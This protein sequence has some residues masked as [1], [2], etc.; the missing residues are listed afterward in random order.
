MHE[1]ANIS[2]LLRKLTCVSEASPLIALRNADGLPDRL[3][4]TDLDV[5]CAP[6]VSLSEAR[7]F[8]RR[9]A[10]STGWRLLGLSNRFHMAAATF[11]HP[12]G[13][14]FLHIDVFRDLSVLGVPLI[15]AE[16]LYRDHLVVNGVR[17]LSPRMETLVTVVHRTLHG[18]TLNKRRYRDQLRFCLESEDG[19]WC[20]E[21]L[22]DILGVRVAQRLEDVAVRDESQ[23]EGWSRG[24]STVSAVISR[25]LVRAPWSTLTRLARYGAGQVTSFLRPPGLVGEPGAA[26]PQMPGLRVDLGFA[27][28]LSIYALSAPTVRAAPTSLATMHPPRYLRML[29][30]RWK[31]WTPLRWILPSIFLWLHAKR[32]GV[33]IVD[34]LPGGLRLLRRA[35]LGRSWIARE[36]GRKAGVFVALLGPDGVG[37]TTIARE[38]IDG[39]EGSTAYVHFR[40]KLLSALPDTPPDT[41]A[42]PVQWG[43]ASSHPGQTLLGWARILRSLTQSWMGYLIRV[44]PILESGGLVIADRWIYRYLTQPRALKYYGPRWLANIVVAVSPRPDLAVF[45][46]GDAAEVL[47][48][49]REVAVADIEREMEAG[50]RVDL[51][52]VAWVCTRGGPEVTVARVRSLWGRAGAPNERSLR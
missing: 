48:R 50:T 9:C 49:K 20:R 18:G 12:G 33:A 2:D 31:F 24:N 27:S 44:R 5:V 3:D 26:V 47:S 29:R 17:R 34:R 42:P 46:T 45:L 37:K 8:L 28:G 52:E 36:P 21:R 14:N 23:G 10:S 7:S 11:V 51:A 16:E 4:G 6:G 1:I 19:E 35:G 22:A 41:E 25:R 40:P 38:L 43:H 32:S 39:H 30:S 15:S 13:K